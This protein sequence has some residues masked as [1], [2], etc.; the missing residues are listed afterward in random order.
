MSDTSATDSQRQR[1]WRLALGRYGDRELGSGQLSR[2]DQRVDRACI[3]HIQP[4]R[5]DPV[6]AKRGK[7]VRVDIRRDDCR[8]KRRQGLR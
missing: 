8:P 5:R 1:R 6:G 4:M 2:S 7:P 3:Q